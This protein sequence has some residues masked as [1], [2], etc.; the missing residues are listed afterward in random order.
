MN[1]SF[2]KLYRAALKRFIRKTFPLWQRLGFHV[3]RVHFY[4]PVPDTRTLK[5]DLWSQPT[6]MPGVDINENKQLQLLNSFSYK[7]KDEYDQFPENKTTKPY[8]YYLN[9][10]SYESV[11]GEML[12]CMIRDFKPHKIVEVG[13]GFSTFIAG[14]AIIKN[15]GEEPGYECDLTSIDPFPNDVIS[16]GF[17]GF[18]GVLPS[19]VQDVELDVFTDLEAND[20]FL[21]DSSHVLSI[22]SDVQYEFLEILP[23][24]KKGVVIHI[25]DIFLPSEYPREWVMG[26]KVFWTEQYLLQ[27]FLAFNES[28]EVLWAS[29]YM[30]HNHA[31]KLSAVFNSYR[32]PVTRP[33]SLWL[34]KIK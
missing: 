33:C 8:E 13:S 2:N 23:R 24:L 29:S 7:Y 18:S 16:G 30:N 3:T 4:E 21:I 10:K 20:I 1:L 32:I 11:D 31:D 17:P 15:L 6:E 5:N 19:T 34:A 9:N 25:H 28:F 12:Y 26:R 22:G 27:A 14:A